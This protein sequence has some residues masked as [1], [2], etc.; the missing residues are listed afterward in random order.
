M[1]DSIRRLPDAELE[2][3]QAVWA[4]PPPVYRAGFCTV[5]SNRCSKSVM[6]IPLFHVA[7]PL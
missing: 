7:S 3:M 5:G 1:A 4:C 2:V 6:A